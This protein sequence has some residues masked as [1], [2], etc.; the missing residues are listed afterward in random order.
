MTCV[1]CPKAG[2]VITIVFMWAIRQSGFWLGLL[3]FI[4]AAVA[5]AQD[6][7]LTLEISPTQVGVGGVVRPGSWMP[8][9]IRVDN[10][11]GSHR[12]VRC[13][14]LLSDIDGDRVVAGRVVSLTGGRVQS[15]WLYAM[16]PLQV[17]AKTTWQVQIKDDKTGALLAATEVV[18]PQLIEPDKAIIA[19]T[20]AGALGL[21]PYQ[22]YHTQHEPI[23]VVRGVGP[24]RLPDRWYGY[25]SLHTLVW[26]PDSLDPSSPVVSSQTLKAVSQ[27][28]HRGGHLVVVL[29]STG[30][31]WTG[32]PLGDL[33]PDVKIET[34]TDVFAPSA[35]G[36]YVQQQTLDLCT[37]H[38]RDEASDV[39][40][41]LWDATGEHP[42][43]VAHQVGFGRV[44]L[45]GIDLTDRRILKMRLPNGPGFW[46][47][48]MRWR[49]PAY[50]PDQIQERE[51][52]EQIVSTLVRTEVETGAFVA[53]LVSMR[54]TYTLALL[55]AMMIFG[56]YWLVAGPVGF[57]ALKYKGHQRHAW[58]GF[59]L[60]ILVFSGITWGGAYMVRP[61]KSK[62]EH[63]SV[64]DIDH[65]AGLVRAYSWL[66]LFVARH[67]EV[68]VAVDPAVKKNNQNTM[69]CPGLP[70]LRKQSVFLDPQTYHFNAA[71]P[72]QISFPFR[73]TAKQLTLS[74]AKGE[75]SQEAKG[76][77][78]YRLPRGEIILQNNWPSGTL[79]H[80]LPGA[81][82]D[83]LW[84][85]CPGNG[86]E[87]WV[88]R[89]KEPWRPGMP[90]T[91]GLSA[92]RKAKPD[93]LIR[94]PS[95][96]APNDWGGYLWQLLGNK[97]LYRLAGNENPNLQVA[98][99][100]IRSGTELLT[101]YD[102]L[103]P[104]KY[105]EPLSMLRTDG[106]IHF[107]RSL[108]RE[109]DWSG[110]THFKRLIFIGYLDE[111]PLPIPMTVDQEVIPSVGRVAVRWMYHLSEKPSAISSQ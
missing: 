23:R 73:S 82:K 63:F 27:W 16:P 94:K 55:L 88:W 59:V 90:L 10:T 108:G 76:Y 98:N 69:A 106:P 89:Q 48:I 26:T 47:A 24:E 30:E 107:M 92:A 33:L 7:S 86:Q 36:L 18:I 60:A 19:V 6:S 68:V 42:V 4:S 77:E 1:S 35:L 12:R 105:W 84:V 44:T 71:S 37:L 91:L 75:K 11:A 29:P 51:K 43:V 28:V 70:P 46:G 81:L 57:Y 66:S 95:R 8:L 83:V 5:Q 2:L 58:T 39:A 56:V 38:P 3:I 21:G 14:W 111:A 15:I 13:Q 22:E 40:V 78:S 34:L 61:T 49:S 87:P 97:P 31:L 72:S 74:W 54:G 103:P 45:V 80:A 64:L 99:N 102:T 93:R 109:L 101:F 41:L 96:S 53:P 9:Q 85:Y 17:D 32:S 104:P 79:V 65:S 52:K 67:G 110:M 50:R 100:E 62:I 20:G 25:Q